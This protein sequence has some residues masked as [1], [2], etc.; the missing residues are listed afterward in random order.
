MQSLP[1]KYFTFAIS[2]KE[3]YL[4]LKLKSFEHASLS[5]PSIQKCHWENAFDVH[6]K[7]VS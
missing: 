1:E 6:V 3:Y 4:P 2:L 7:W 5:H